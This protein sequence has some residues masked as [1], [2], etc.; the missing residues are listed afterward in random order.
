MSTTIPVA[1][2]RYYGNHLV[3]TS[4]K[5]LIITYLDHILYFTWQTLLTLQEEKH[6]HWNYEA[7]VRSRYRFLTDLK[8]KCHRG[9]ITVYR[10]TFLQWVKMQHQ[11]SKPV[12]TKCRC[13]QNK[14]GSSWVRQQTDWPL[15]LMPTWNFRGSE[16]ASSLKW[17]CNCLPFD[18]KDSTL[19]SNN[20]LKPRH[21]HYKSQFLPLQVS[22]EKK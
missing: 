14:F 21:I 6:A 1:S 12:R 18:H 16:S 15:Q 19:R 20:K 5:I 2:C 10:L 9:S 17:K 13:P 4:L 7:V 8:N 11:V 3:V 22:F